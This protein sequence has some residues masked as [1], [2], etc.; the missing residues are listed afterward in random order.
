MKMNYSL[1]KDLIKYVEVYQAEHP[2]QKVEDFTVW[3]NNQLFSGSKSHETGTHD[4]LLIA[5]KVMHL[6]KELKRQTKN[7]LSEF[8]VSSIDEYSFLLHLHY[9]ESFRKMEL[10]ELHN[11][12]APTGIEIIKRL[13]KSAFIEEFPDPNDGRAKRIKITKKGTEE[14]MQMKPKIDWAFTTFTDSLSL[15]EKIEVSAILDKLMK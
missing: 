8:N 13:L 6:N 2:S 5:F 1:L 11:L 3:L 14:L 12:E 15:S 7:I 4:E 10:V 9:Q